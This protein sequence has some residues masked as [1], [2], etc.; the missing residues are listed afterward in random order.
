MVDEPSFNRHGSNYLKLTPLPVSPNAQ[1]LREIIAFR[2]QG[3]VVSVLSSVY[4]VLLS[5]FRMSSYYTWMHNR[6]VHL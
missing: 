4:H 1:E 5:Q 3:L 2:S 6:F